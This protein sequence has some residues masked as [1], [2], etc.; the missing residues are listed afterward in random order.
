MEQENKQV[1][2]IKEEQLRADHNGT[3]LVKG[4]TSSDRFIVD[5]VEDEEEEE[6]QRQ[7]SL[8]SLM[9]SR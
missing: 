7:N 9:S 5:D 6:M 3:K 2:I 1:H 8:R 4:Q